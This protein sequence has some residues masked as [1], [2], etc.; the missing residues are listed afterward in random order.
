MKLRVQFT[1]GKKF[2]D[3]YWLEFRK[4]DLY[5]GYSQL[6]DS[7]KAKY[8]YHESGQMHIKIGEEIICKDK[9]IPLGE[10]KGVMQ[11]SGFGLDNKEIR[12]SRA[13]DVKSKKKDVR[14]IVD[15]RTL[16]KNTMFYFMIGIVEP[17]KCFNLFEERILPPFLRDKTKQIL[18]CTEVNPW[19][20]VI[21][22]V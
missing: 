15:S 13:D 5:Y 4:N 16:P 2:V 12:F 1:N 19:V 10:F 9:S 17:D 6:V 11:L 7:D 14:L 22:H 21:F 18:I 8:S 20:W 3:L